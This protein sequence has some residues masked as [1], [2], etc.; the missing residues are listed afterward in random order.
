MT[1]RPIKIHIASTV[2]TVSIEFE[3]DLQ[4]VYLSAEQ[5]NDLSKMLA[6]HAIEAGF[7]G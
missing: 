7:K 6:K 4:I 5:A 3:K 2:D 1:D